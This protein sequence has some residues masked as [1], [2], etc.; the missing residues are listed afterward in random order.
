M[1]L[2]DLAAYIEFSRTLDLE[3]NELVQ[4][5]A[6]AVRTRGFPQVRDVVPALG[7]MALHFDPAFEGDVVATASAIVEEVAKKRLPAADDVGRDVEVPVC[8]D[9]EFALDLQELGERTRLKSEEIARIFC[10]A[11]YRV[12]MIGFA[13]GHAYLG[14]LPERL[15]VPRRAL[16]RAV[17]PAG[18]V[19]I[20]NRQA[21]VYPFAISGGW[22]VLGR[23]PL[24]L[25]D[26]SRS[27]PSFFGPGD[28]V[29]FKAVERKEF[30][31]LKENP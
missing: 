30:E 13:P 15:A 11:S 1:P 18:S 12:L 5:L 2:G 14:G 27:R 28:R 9:A 26:A 23:T 22:S 24:T 29:R 20:A 31:S 25:F 6:A 16:P 3:V 4:R 8:F 17:V 21:V 19:A 10:G 7:G